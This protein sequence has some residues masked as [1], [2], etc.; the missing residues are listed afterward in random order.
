MSY[1]LQ[2]LQGG[3]IGDYIE[4]STIGVTK[5]N[6]GSLDY[7]WYRVLGLEFMV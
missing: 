3:Y 6:T 7:S 4:E 5:G 1:S 2:S